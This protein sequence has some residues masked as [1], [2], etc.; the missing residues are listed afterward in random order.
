[1]PTTATAIST[2]AANRMRIMVGVTA[3]DANPS[4]ADAD[5]VRG[6]DVARLVPD[7][8]CLGWILSGEPRHP[9]CVATEVAME[10][11]VAIDSPGELSR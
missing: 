5:S 4:V 8:M 11:Y 6:R 1:V 10:T 9:L 3:R 2:A 7:A